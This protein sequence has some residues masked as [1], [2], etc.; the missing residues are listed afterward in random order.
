MQLR[1]VCAS[2]M[3]PLAAPSNA[4]EQWIQAVSQASELAQT[5]RCSQVSIAQVQECLNQWK[6]SDYSGKPWES[7]LAD[8]C[9]AFMEHCAEILEIAGTPPRL[10][11]NL[12]GAAVRLAE[13]VGKTGLLVAAADSDLVLL[14]ERVQKLKLLYDV[15]L[16]R[17]EAVAGEAAVADARAKKA[18]EEAGFARG[19]CRQLTKSLRDK[20]TAAE[21][22]IADLT[23]QVAQLRAPR[24]GGHSPIARR[25]ANAT[26]KGRQSP[27]EESCSSSSVPFD[28]DVDLDAAPE[29]AKNHDATQ[30]QRLQQATALGM[31]RSAEATEGVVEATTPVDPLAVLAAAAI[32]HLVSLVKQAQQS[33]PALQLP[34]PENGASTELGARETAE[35]A[36][37]W[38]D[39]VLAFHNPTLAASVKQSALHLDLMASFSN[40]STPHCVQSLLAVADAKR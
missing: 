29:L 40:P 35:V 30:R 32:D 13:V 16:P 8:C 27:R 2:L 23:K 22:R 31:L 12:L 18:E 34:W 14:S 33:H 28:A 25:S 26:G 39:R 21:K 37:L 11:S 36:K 17:V 3:T 4:W 38:A 10:A 5:V 19:E 24:K 20:L 6:L 7:S 1:E 9:H 15:L